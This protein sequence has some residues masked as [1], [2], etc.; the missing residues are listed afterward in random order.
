VQ[1]YNLVS[2]PLH[3]NMLA[4]WHYVRAKWELSK[5]I[6]HL[7]GK[8]TRFVSQKSV[9]GVLHCLLAIKMQTSNKMSRK[10][11]RKQVQQKATRD[12]A[13]ASAANA[14]PAHANTD[15]ICN[16][17]PLSEKVSTQQDKILV[18]E[19]VAADSEQQGKWHHLHALCKVQKNLWHAHKIL[20][21][22]LYLLNVEEVRCSSLFYFSSS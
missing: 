10:K 17:H 4:A 8:T 2:V 16:K 15:P 18:E 14:T 9:L 3:T 19:T 5:I 7:V 11:A 21:C 20:A 1:S 13:E 22:W 12:A 6:M